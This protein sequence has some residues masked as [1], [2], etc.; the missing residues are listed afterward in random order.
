RAGDSGRLLGFVETTAGLVTVGGLDAF[1]DTSAFHHVALTYDGTTVK[2]FVDGVL[3]S[4]EP[5]TGAVRDTS[6]PVLIGRRSGSGF[7]GHGDDL[8]GLV[9]E[10]AVYNRALSDAEV[11]PIATGPRTIAPASALPTISDAVVIDGY[12]QPGAVQNSDPN[13]FNGTLLIELDG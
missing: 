1:S 4:S 11:Q 5:L 9:D 6:F 10:L 13:G 2:F 12:T 8:N 7:D 3:E